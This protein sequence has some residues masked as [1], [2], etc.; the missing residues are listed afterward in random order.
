MTYFIFNSSIDSIHLDSG[1]YTFLYGLFDF[2]PNDNFNSVSSAIDPTS[3]NG[4]YNLEIAFT[5][6]DGSCE[7]PGCTDTNALNFN[8]LAS[9]TDDNACIYP[10]DMGIIECGTSHDYSSTPETNYSNFSK[11]EL[12]EDLDVSFTLLTSGSLPHIFLYNNEYQ[13]IHIL[14]SSHSVGL[15]DTVLSLNTGTYYL[16]FTQQPSYTSNSDFDYFTDDYLHF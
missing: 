5:L 8:S 14:D 15:L 2:Y 12:I 11:F 1:E 7:Y 9:L 4:I 3:T 16:A 13:L 10:V 6:Y